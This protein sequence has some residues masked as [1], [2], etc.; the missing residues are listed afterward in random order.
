VFKIVSDEREG[1]HGYPNHGD[2]GDGKGGKQ[3]ALV[4][5]AGGERGGGPAGTLTD[6]DQR[7]KQGSRNLRDIETGSRGVRDGGE[8]QEQEGR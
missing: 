3:S 4:W 8:Q 7:K 5:E 1:Q 2:D 6:E